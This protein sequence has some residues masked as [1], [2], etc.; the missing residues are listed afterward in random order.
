M[1]KFIHKKILQNIGV[2]VWRWKTE[3]G[4]RKTEVKRSV[5]RNA[6]SGE[7]KVEL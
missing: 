6:E 2:R 5:E 3:D 7:R 4:R 1:K